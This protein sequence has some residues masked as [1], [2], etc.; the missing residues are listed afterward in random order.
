MG[1]STISMVIFNSYV[2]IA[3]PGTHLVILGLAENRFPEGV[4]LG[5]PSGDHHREEHIQLATRLANI[6]LYNHILL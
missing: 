5:I 4:F 6:R 2:D 3:R 1:K